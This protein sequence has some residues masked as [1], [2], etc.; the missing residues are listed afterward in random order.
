MRGHAEPSIPTLIDEDIFATESVRVGRFRCSPNHPTF[1]TAGAISQPVVVFPRCPVWIRHAGARPFIA[2][3]NLATIYNRGQEYTREPLSPEGDRSDYFAVT[4]DVAFAIA[5]TI[6]SPARED[7]ERPFPVQYASTGLSLYWRQRALFTRLRAAWVDPLEAEQEVLEI[8][9]AVLRQAAPRRRRARWT[10][11]SNDRLRDLVTGAQELIGR[12]L[13]ALT[14]VTSLARG[15]GVS[16][17]HLCRVFRMHTG[18]TLHGYRLEL[19]VRAALEE[20][21][22]PAGSLSQIAHHLGFSSHSHFT[23]TFHR[24]LGVTPANARRTLQGSS[25]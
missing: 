8:V 25:G 3:S 10:R 20:L 5:G 13:A 6:F 15:L 14:T 23:A 16:P 21:G 17:F 18:T 1:R 24:R 7:P 2:D 4:P 11:T 22:K 9:A 19:R 12:D